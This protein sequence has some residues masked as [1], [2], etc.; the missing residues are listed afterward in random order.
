M[1]KRNIVIVSNIPEEDTVVW[2]FDFYFENDMELFE[3]SVCNKV[4]PS[5]IK[6]STSN[7][8]E[9]DDPDYY[10]VI[11][12]SDEVKVDLLTKWEQFCTDNNVHVIG[13]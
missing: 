11:K 2:E 3:K 1:E 13:M 8:L 9:T 6:K 7:K 12:L 4:D 5:L 10:I